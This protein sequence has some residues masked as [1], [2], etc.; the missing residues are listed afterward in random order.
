MHYSWNWGVFFDS[1]GVGDEIYLDWYISGLGWTIA[2]ALSAWVVALALGTVLGVLRTV[3]NRWLRAIGTAYV[4][5]FRNVPLL[6]QLFIWYFLVPDLLPEGAQEW[7]KQDLNPTTS[8]FISVMICLGLF[9]A[10]RVC[11]QV[12]T[13]IESLPRGQAAAARAMGF[14]TRQIYR[15]VLLPQAFRII[16]PPLTSEFLNVFKNSSVASLIGLMELLAQTKQTAEFSARLFEAFTLATLIYFTLNMS[17]M[18]L[19]RLVE[20]RALVPGMI[21][22]GGK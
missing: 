12:R 3:P 16:I 21:S 20:K 22:A 9:T 1:T 18:L 19:M 17:L 2:I 13:G 5:L 8:A 15:I 6:V 7:F 11:E 10:A 4:E 14:T